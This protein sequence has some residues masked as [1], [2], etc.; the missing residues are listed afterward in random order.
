MLITTAG[1]NPG[2][3]IVKEA[4]QSFSSSAFVCKQEAE[5]DDFAFDTLV[6]AKLTLKI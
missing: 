4:A 2:F 3:E 6:K 1:S 5:A